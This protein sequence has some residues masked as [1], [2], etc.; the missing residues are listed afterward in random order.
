MAEKKNNNFVLAI[1]VITLVLV[2]FSMLT[3][4][5]PANVPVQ[6]KQVS[7]VGG[8]VKLSIASQPVTESGKVTLNIEKPTSAS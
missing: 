2:V 3:T 1:L 8:E 6:Q 7:F 5:L 4:P